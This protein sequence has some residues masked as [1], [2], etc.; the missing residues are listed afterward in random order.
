MIVM[1]VDGCRAGWIA[2]CWG[3]TVAHR[4]YT[5][6][7]SLVETEAQVIAVDMPIGFPDQAGRSAE[8]E[9]RRV[10]GARKSSLFAMPCRAAVMCEDYR[11]AC[12]TNLQNSDPPRKISK[13][14]FH[15]FPKIRE[16]DALIT[17]AKQNRIH[18]VHPELAFWHMNGKRPLSHAKKVQGRPS[19]LGL[20]QRRELLR[21]A[22]FPLDQLPLS[23]YR[24]SDV[25]ADDL[26]D[27]CACAVVARRIADGRA[28]YFPVVP[29]YDGRGLLMR[30]A[31]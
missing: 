10:L 6:F 29:E 4:L 3:E 12:A 19:E 11:E 2:V 1:G 31:C 17:P 26:M 5:S 13:Q 21:N 25:G 14:A 30:I 24:K 7:A 18:E 23:I 20:E 16:I 9:A 8:T 27:A 15:L 22:G 28:S